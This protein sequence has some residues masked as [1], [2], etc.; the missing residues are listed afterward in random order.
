MTG[1][2][3]RTIFATIF[4]LAA[5]AAHADSTLKTL[6]QR[7][8]LLAGITADSPPVSISMPRTVRS[9]TVPT[10]PVISPGGSA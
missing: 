4:C 3:P 2:L 5:A 8:Q 9:A 6:L 10:S 7:K 1:M